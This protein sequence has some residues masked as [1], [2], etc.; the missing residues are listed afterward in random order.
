LNIF[1][2][3]IF[4]HTGTGAT[5]DSGGTINATSSDPKSEFWII[6]GKGSQNGIH[7]IT[8]ISITHDEMEVPII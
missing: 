6:F 3:Y 2:F 5:R 4:P 8:I 7:Y 1:L